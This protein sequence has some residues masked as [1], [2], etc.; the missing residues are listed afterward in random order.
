M[1][2]ATIGISENLVQGVKK[3]GYETPTEIQLQSIPAAVDGRD[4][5]GS[6]QTGTG[7]TAAFVL[8]MLHRISQKQNGHRSRPCLR[9]LI[10]T[11]TRELAVQIEQSIRTYGYYLKL[12]SLAVYGGVNIKNQIKALRNGV[13][14]VA[15]TPGRL[16][17]HLQRKTI[18]LGSVEILVV[19]EADRMFDMGFIDDVR[20]II[21]SIPEN[22]QT[23]LFSATIS[24]EVRALAR[25]VQKSPQMV[26]VGPVNNPVETVSHRAYK[27][28]HDMKQ[29]FLLHLLNTSAM[30]SVL[31]F[32]RTK[33]R[34]DRIA[35]RLLREDISAVAMH[36]DRTQAQRE[37]AL[38]GFKNGRFRVMV[39]T[40]IAARGIDVTGISHVINYDLPGSAEDYVHRIGRTGRALAAGEAIT[41][42]ARDEEKSLV[43]IER[44]IKCKL[45]LRRH[46]DFPCTKE[47]PA[48]TNHHMP[49]KELADKNEPKRHQRARSVQRT[50]GGLKPSVSTGRRNR[51]KARDKTRGSK[52]KRNRGGLLGKRENGAFQPGKKSPHG[53]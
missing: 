6:A 24:D 23:M 2:F 15:A 28:E 4:I 42:V 26:Q 47:H 40:D 33:R 34:A 44:V 51:K 46:S 14:I 20:R 8:P 29:K 11:P 43:R 17:D 22:R 41:F 31:V 38:G 7:K 39:A 5:F 25:K 21:R 35:K 50:Q 30:T 53:K 37:K 52:R 18:D 16:L 49:E 10:I 12:R 9:G 36:S 48:G 13:D 32:S 3:T 1:S 27:V 19:D 45:N